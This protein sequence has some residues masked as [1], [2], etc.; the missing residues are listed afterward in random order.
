VT[1]E[2][3]LS[4]LEA[5]PTYIKQGTKS[6]SITLKYPRKD[7]D[8]LYWAGIRSAME[9]PDVWM[10]LC[11][12]GQQIPTIGVI[13]NE[14]EK[15]EPFPTDSVMYCFADP[16]LKWASGTPPDTIA[17]LLTYDVRYASFYP[18]SQIHAHINY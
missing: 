13:L 17:P 10:S 4:A 6:T 5:F 16:P 9:S 7:L 15:F 1:Q 11:N 2:A 18:E 3:V 14:A 8:G 12:R